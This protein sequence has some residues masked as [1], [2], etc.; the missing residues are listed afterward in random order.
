MR[1]DGR[2]DRPAPTAAVKVC[3]VHVGLRACWPT[4]D[5]AMVYAPASPFCCR[6]EPS[7][8][9]SKRDHFCQPAFNS[10]DVTP[11]V[12]RCASSHGE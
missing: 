10:L 8:R 11:D 12:G 7:R 1:D 3:V 4:T 2:N 6:F 5:V 9:R